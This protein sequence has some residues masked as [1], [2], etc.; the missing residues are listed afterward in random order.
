VFQRHPH[1]Y[2]KALAALTVAVGV[3]TAAPPAGAC[4]ATALATLHRNPAALAPR[5]NVS[6]SRPGK[7]RPYPYGLDAFTLR[8]RAA[9]VK[10]SGTVSAAQ[11]SASPGFDYV[12]AT[13]GAAAALGAVVLVGGSAVMVR[14][15]TTPPSAAV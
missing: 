8:Q 5:S 4:L 13:I 6:N 12:D 11:V 2:R 3:C 15:H 7:L 1:T 10:R 14:R 9:A